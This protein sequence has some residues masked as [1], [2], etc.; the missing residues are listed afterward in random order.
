MKKISLSIAMASLLAGSAAMAAHHEED[1][2]IAKARSAAPAAISAEA[3]VM[4][5]DGTV[6]KEGT[7]GWTCFPN[8]GPRP[9]SDPVCGDAVWKE[10]LTRDGL[11]IDKAAL[12]PGV[13]YMLASDTPHIM[14]VVA[15]EGGFESLN[16]T[17]GAGKTW[18][19][20]PDK[21]GRHAMIPIAIVEPEMAKKEEEKE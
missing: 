9:E 13:S 21:P 4:L 12:G 2:Q 5:L 3:T 10:Y 16:P 7:N 1:P 19:M 6:L 14:V 18:I 11:N 15:E 20:W 8:I 17:P